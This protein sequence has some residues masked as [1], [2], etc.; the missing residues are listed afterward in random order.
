MSK[1]NKL[2]VLLIG[3]TLIGIVYAEMSK[4]KQLNWFASYTNHHKIPFGAYVFSDLIESRYDSVIAVNRPPYEYLKDND[5]Q[6]TYLFFNDGLG[7]GEAE[8]ERLL[9]W[10]SRGNNLFLASSDFSYN[11]LDTLNLETSLVSIPGNF[12]NEFQFKLINNRLHIEDPIVFDKALSLYHFSEIDSST[13]VV[14]ILDKYQEGPSQIKDTLINIIKKP[15]GEGQIILSTIPQAFTNYFILEGTNREYTAGLMSYIN[16]GEPLY[17]DS[18]Y[19][20]GKTFYASPLYLFLSNPNLKWAY[21]LLLF[22]AL[23]YVVFEG[24]RK[25]RAIPIIEPLKNQTVDYTRTIANM[26]YE[27]SAHNEIGRHV[28]QHFLNY[29]RVHFHLQTAIIN[30]LFLQQL[31]SRSNNT[32]EDT[33]RL[34]GFIENLEKQNFVRKEELGRLNTLI[35]KF[36]S[37]T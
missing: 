20:S 15:F 18:Y 31:A 4:P 14:G 2:Y 13:S 10:T 5:I 27:R 22:G 34:F 23:V 6:G 8:F 1:R 7:F 12:N 24:K 36:K 28:I 11:V 30:D 35:E 25:Q 33:K 29:I 21:Y 3:L 19:K 17:M 16:P 32:L 9:D 26:Y 37:Q